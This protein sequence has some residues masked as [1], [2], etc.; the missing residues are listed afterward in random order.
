MTMDFRSSVEAETSMSESM[1]AD[2][3]QTM[4]AGR[5]I[6]YYDETGSTNEDVKLLAKKEASHGTLVVA[7]M[8]SAGRGRKGRDWQSPAGTTISMSI[9]LRPEFAPDKA[10]SLTLVMAMAIARAIKEVCGCDCQIKWPNDLVLNRKKVCGI[11]TEMSVEKG[12]IQYVVIGAGVNVNLIDFPEEI[13]E[14]ATSILKE[15]GKRVA[16]E[17]LIAC[18][19]Y[20]LE[21]YYDIYMRTLDLSALR[22]EYNQL[23]INLDA[24]VRVLDPKGAYNGIAR[25]I[26]KDGE[27]IVE[28]ENGDFE[29]VYAGEVSV[30][31]LYGYV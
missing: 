15:T 28:K 2:C 16:R 8:Q 6:Y 12:R 23:L 24:Q 7:N 20:F 4:W 5:E 3:L 29:E 19:M 14:M 13:K 18:S 11:L 26:T 22:E 31:G 25:G 27:L 21:Q 30:R 10:S 1:I 17:E 9:L